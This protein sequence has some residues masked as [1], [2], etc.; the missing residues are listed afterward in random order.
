MKSL[1]IDMLPYDELL[2]EVDEMRRIMRKWLEYSSRF[3]MFRCFSGRL[4]WIPAADVHETPEAY[5][6]FVDLAGIDPS[7]I[8][9]VVEDNLLYLSGE[10]RRPRVDSCDRIHQLEIDFGTFRRVFQFPDGLNADEAES[11]YREG[12]LEIVLPKAPGSPSVQI[13]LKCD[14]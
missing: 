6:I 2:K 1:E 11:I 5:H 4:C 9:L 12:L 8:D 3:R 7:T 10:R 13:P 14:R